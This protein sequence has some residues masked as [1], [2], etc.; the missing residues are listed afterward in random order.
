MRKVETRIK[1]I[2]KGDDV[3]Y[4]PQVKGYNQ[5]RVE[6][7]FYLMPLFGQLF[8]VV[9]LYGYFK[10]LFWQELE[11]SYNWNDFEKSLPNEKNAKRKIDEFYANEINLEKPIKHKTQVSYIKYP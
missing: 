9:A 1:V 3:K 2:T 10:S 6:W 4:I 5:A 7:P 11:E 8:L